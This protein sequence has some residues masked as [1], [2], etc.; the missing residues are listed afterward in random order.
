VGVIFRLLGSIGLNGGYLERIAAEVFERIVPICRPRIR[1]SFW[2][3]IALNQLL[4]D[5]SPN[6]AH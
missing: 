3:R 5:A 6:G 2:L 4:F 1:P